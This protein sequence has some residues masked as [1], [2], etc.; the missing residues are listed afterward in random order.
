MSIPNSFFDF[1]S[2]QTSLS[3]AKLGVVGPDEALDPHGARSL[4]A[5]LVLLTPQAGGLGAAGAD[6]NT[7][8][9]C[10]HLSASSTTLR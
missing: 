9:R 4:A 6:R 10:R 1:E 8:H 7:L 3:E 5:G 2:G